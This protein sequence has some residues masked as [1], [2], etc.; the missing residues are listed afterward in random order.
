M[1]DSKWIQFGCGLSAPGDWLNFD[2][3]PTLRLQQLPVIGGLVP[4]GPYGRFPNN[5][6]YGDIVAGLPVPERSV[7]LLYCSHV[8][9]HLALADLRT[10]LRNCRR[11]LKSGGMFRL[12]LP[13]L[14]F[15]ISEY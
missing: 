8:L 3:S 5:V 9:E 2:S 6:R 4:T 13:D 14:E 7:E 1:A 10:A 12:V 15:L 11:V